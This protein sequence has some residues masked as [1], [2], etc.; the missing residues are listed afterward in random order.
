MSNT[1]FLAA[2][3]ICISLSSTLAAAETTIATPSAI[4]NPAPSNNENAP[5]VA[6]VS[7]DTSIA[8]APAETSAP[9]DSNSQ[10]SN[11]ASESTVSESKPTLIQR[12]VD[13]IGEIGNRS[14][15]QVAALGSKIA[16]NANA[17]Q[18]ESVKDPFEHFNRSIYN[19]NMKLDK[20]ILLPVATTYKKVLPTPVRH[21]ITNFFV[22]LST[23]WT[24]VNNLLQGH[25]GTSIESLSRFVINTATS[26]GFYD[27]AS[28]L[29]VE[30]SDEDFGLTLGTWGVGSG[31]YI[32]L[33]F[34]GPSTVRDTFSRLVDQFGAPQDYV[35]NTWELLGV[36]GLK[37][38]DLRSRLIG[39][40]T[41]IAGDQYTLLRDVYLQKRQFENGN[42]TTPKAD[43]SQ[44]SGFTNND[45]G[46]DGFGDSDS[47]QQKSQ[48]TNT[49]PAAQ[50]QHDSSSAPANTTDNPPAPVSSSSDPASTPS[51]PDVGTPTQPAQF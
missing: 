35:L 2:L 30:K 41:F 34:F 40:E 32:M 28:V 21:G 31:P 7:T 17:S 45:F 11:N 9:N 27:T 10:N 14:I 48:S 22:N 23:P 12:S 39:L 36:T 8:E 16:V 37:Y 20:Y 5:V 33:P 1:Q 13:K 42:P 6:A 15:E 51:A 43:A 38:V 46:D 29:G 3:G 47:S 26:L 49:T 25:P 4:E 44:D 19:F 50:I 18:P 24:A